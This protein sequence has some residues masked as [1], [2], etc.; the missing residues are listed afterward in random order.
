MTMT[1]FKKSSNG[2]QTPNETELQA[3]QQKFSDFLALLEANNK[4]LKIIADMEEKSQ[5]TH[6]FDVGYIRE[7]LESVRD[8][9]RQI[10]SRLIAMG[11]EKYRLLER[12]YADIDAAIQGQMP[13]LSDV[14]RDAFTIDFSELSSDRELSVGSKNAQLGEMKNR[15][16][17]PV[18]DGF[19]ISAWSYKHFVESNNLQSRINSLIRS[20]DIESHEDLVRVSDEIRNLV[21]SSPVPDNLADAIKKSRDE[22]KSRSSIG[23][24]SMR[25]SAIGEDTLFSFAGQYRSFLNV[26]ARELVQRYVDV[27][28]G[29]FTPKAIYY[30]LSHS[31][32][33]TDLAMSVGC[34]TMV[35]AAASGVAYTRDPIRP[36]ADC[37]LVNSIYGLGSHLVDGTLTPDVFCLCRKTGEVLSSEIV[38]KPIRL[39]LREEG[40]TVNE[41]VPS[42]EQMLP[43]IDEANLKLL[44]EIAIKLEEH[45]RSPQDIEWA[46]DRNGQ[47]LILQTRPLQV[48]KMKDVKVGVDP[49]ILE[50]FICGG[51]TV[52]P[53]ADAGPIFKLTSPKDIPAVPNGAVLVAR[54]PFPGLVTVMEKI[55]ALVT[56]VGGVVSHMATLA[57]EYH[58]PTLVG[59]SCMDELVKGEDVT[60]DATG[61]AI[62]RGIH[63]ELVKS[64]SLQYEKLEDLPIFRLLESVLDHISPLNLVNPTGNKFLAENCATFH[65]ITRFAHQKSIEEMFDAA[66]N[67]GGKETLGFKLESDLP[68]DMSIIFIDDSADHYQGKKSIPD[69]EITS[70]PMRAFWSGIL[71]EGWPS[72]GPLKGHG[73]LR[74]MVTTQKTRRKNAQ[75][76]E[77][78]FAIL[79]KEYMIAGLHMG[80]HITTI[81]AICTTDISKNFIRMQYKEGG[82]ALDRRIRRVKLISDILNSV[83]FESG[84]RGDFFNS[85]I[86]YLGRHE[87]LDR[88]YLLGRLS[89]LTKQLDMALHNDD[90]AEWYKK[91]IM[92]RLGILPPE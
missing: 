16:K 86:S 57:R 89:I 27:L 84:R 34:V 25:S 66:E 3:V 55:S 92:K 37:I 70:E 42:E 76:S 7:N 60:V 85:S 30:L 24:F 17:L 47:L 73:R 63:S 38:S 45:Y 15:L 58:V 81:E 75:F 20:L 91:D 22:L 10:T 9:V 74:S 64:R 82:A 87:I 28:A 49:S 78:S 56:E 65:D 61:G 53:G 5:G 62:Y 48:L 83:G 41:P 54:H 29:K 50:A 32:A 88:L 69:N 59:I 8:G 40:G 71:K 31:L 79:S 39:V 2:E 6:L 18:P 77:S 26:R 43:S 44:F 13:G 52:C 33:E 4:V 68:L 12:R 14:R 35:D 21:S 46:L 67:L 51:T 23:R 1:P 36:D 80:Y 19:A 72:I 90:I 11:G